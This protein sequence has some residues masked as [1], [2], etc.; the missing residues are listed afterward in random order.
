MTVA[1]CR[2]L[3]AEGRIGRA[4]PTVICVT[5]NGLKTQ[6]AIAGPLPASIAPTMTAFEQFLS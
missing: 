1:A 2:R 3:A 6:E 5:G 4:E